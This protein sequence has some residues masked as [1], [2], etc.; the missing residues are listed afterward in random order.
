[1]LI[2]L[3][4]FFIALVFS[5]FGMGGGLFY[6]PLFLLFFDS[7][8]EASVLSFSCILVTSLSAM[9]AYYQKKLI[10]WKLIGYLGIPLATSIFIT[11]FLLKCAPVNF[12][13]II[14]GVTL[15]FAGILM[16]FPFNNYSLLSKRYTPFKRLNADKRYSVSPITTS[17]LAFVIGLFAGMAGV[18]GG[19]FDIPLM[20]GILKVSAHVAVA[21]SS[22]IIVMASLSG[23]IG[24]LVSNSA[25]FTI[26]AE[27][28]IILLCAFLGAQIGP[29]I[30]LK[31]NKVVF[32]KICGIF[33]ILIGIIY[34]F[35]GFL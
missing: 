3:N 7:F 35:K 13:K 26:S 8:Q 28:V 31:V 21:T 11:G 34:M 6:M 22:A 27:F 23:W 14:F 33:I 1:M 5:M 18:A 17:P 24:R 12:L 20:V 32:K 9:I 15:F 25:A 4:V 29:R 19:V 16:S 2:A 10:D 30:S